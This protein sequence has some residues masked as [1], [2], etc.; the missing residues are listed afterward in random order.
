MPPLSTDRQTLLGQLQQRRQ[1]YADLYLLCDEAVHAME[2][3]TETTGMILNG[4]MAVYE[5][6]AGM[7]RRMEKSQSLS[8]IDTHIKAV[9]AHPENQLIEAARA[10]VRPVATDAREVAEQLRSLR[11]GLQTMVVDGDAKL[12]SATPKKA[13]QLDHLL[14][15]MMEG[16][17]PAYQKTYLQFRTLGNTAPRPG[18]RKDGLGKDRGR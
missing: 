3:F 14:N 4:Q 18:L 1:C 6:L 11:L 2:H 9:E 8:A 16:F 13:V 15:Y 7:R 5:R 10:Q 12:E 17:M